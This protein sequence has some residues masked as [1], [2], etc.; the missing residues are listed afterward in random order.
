MS[1]WHCTLDSTEGDYYDVFIRQDERPTDEQIAK[2][3]T[4]VYSENMGEYLQEALNNLDMLAY[5]IDDEII[6]GN[7]L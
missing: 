4:K 3:M 6:E 1:I 7:T 2:A 5:V